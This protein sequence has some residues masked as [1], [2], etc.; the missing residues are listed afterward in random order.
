MRRNGKSRKDQRRFDQKQARNAKSAYEA[1]AKDLYDEAAETIASCNIADAVYQHP[2]TRAKL[3]VGGIAAATSKD[4]LTGSEGHM[5]HISL[6]VDCCG[7]HVKRPWLPKEIQCKDFDIGLFHKRAE[8]L[9]GT[10]T[11]R[12]SKTKN[13][14]NASE[15]ESYP[16]LAF[17][18]EYFAV[19]DET[20]SLGRNVLVHC[21]AGAHRAGTAGIGYRMYAQWKQLHNILGTKFWDLHVQ[22]P[23]LVEKIEEEYCVVDLSTSGSE[24]EDQ[25]SDK[26]S[27]S[28]CNLNAE[29]DESEKTPEKVLDKESSSS[30]DRLATEEEPNGLHKNEASLDEKR[31]DPG[32][33]DLDSFAFTQCFN[34][35][36]GKRA[37]VDPFH[38]K[39][40]CSYVLADLLK[41]LE[42]ELQAA[43]IHPKAR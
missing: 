4:F 34:Y 12:M 15:L 30:K 6:I 2:V 41:G 29:S 31:G 38:A 27:D 1:G 32:F 35:V 22:D 23:K 14:S 33:V 8:Y 25:A 37:V 39:K 20:L 7:L 24:E 13:A 42:G 11:R 18:A 21:R 9:L 19:V 10:G 43:Q 40:L 3:F 5:P 36:R 17:F 26:G 28:G 16:V